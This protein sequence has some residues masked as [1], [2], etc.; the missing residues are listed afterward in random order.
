MAAELANQRRQRMLNN[1]QTD[2][3]FRRTAFL[4]FSLRAFTSDPFAD[5]GVILGS[6]RLD[7]ILEDVN[8]S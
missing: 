7:I 4:L 2:R 6:V 1:T 5:V 8:N 3:G